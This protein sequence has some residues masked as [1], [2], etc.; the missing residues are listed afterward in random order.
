MCSR[1][2]TLIIQQII[3]N[4]M[5]VNSTKSAFPGLSDTNYI[6]YESSISELF[7]DI[8]NVQSMLIDKLGG[9][10]KMITLVFIQC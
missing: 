2:S 7:H 4:A 1:Y 6:S 10:G 3:N 9:G 8:F 5:I